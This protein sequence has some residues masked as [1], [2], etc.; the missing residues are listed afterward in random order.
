[1]KSRHY[2]E[3]DE[4]LLEN[5]KKWSDMDFFYIKGEVG[6]RKGRW[7]IENFLKSSNQQF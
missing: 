2:P 7:E 1:M 5:F 4:E 6:N 3:G